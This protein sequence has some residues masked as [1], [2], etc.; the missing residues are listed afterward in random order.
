LLLSLVALVTIASTVLVATASSQAHE[1]EPEA[2]VGSWAAAP[3]PGLLPGPGVEE[4]S[5]NGFHDQ[6]VRMIVHSSVGGHQARVRL[7][8]R[9]G[10]KPLTVGHATLALPW[11]DAG[12]GDLRPNTIHELLFHGQ[13]S[14]TVPP[15][16]AVFS[17]VTTMDVPAT[18]DV[19]ISVFLPGDTGPPTLHFNAKSTSYIGPGDNAG[20]PSGA[21]LS[22]TVR[23][24]YF[25]SGL[26]VLNRSG[27]GAIAI[28]GDSISEGFAS[29]SNANRRWPD[30]LAARLA[31]K[32]K[33]R[34]PGVLNVAI[35]GNRLGHDGTEWKNPQT[36]VNASARFYGDVVGQTGVRA[37]ILELGIND[38]WIS[39]DDT[40]AIIGEMQ[41]LASLAHEKGIR[42]YTATIMPWNAFSSDP[43]NNVVNYTPALDS[44]RLAVNSYIRT[45]GDFDGIIDFDVA[46]R[47]PADPSKLKAAWDS[48]DHIH[49]N[50]A[51]NEAMANAVPLDMLARL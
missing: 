26:D 5:V 25:L 47:D 14:V 21:N 23:T 49:P 19:A 50:D 46:M 11:P 3:A 40:N 1:P 45:T 8:N 6:T 36:G 17:D 9:F 24:W 37:V 30:F 33:A 4:L 41:Q 31:K 35:S 39:H 51:G 34:A 18:Q 13:K 38:I 32:D 29:T 42:I 22:K 7:T 20:A 48:G 27:A 28:L 10:T 43:K 15:G 2:W 16:G 12:A 44:I